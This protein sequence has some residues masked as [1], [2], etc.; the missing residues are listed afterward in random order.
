MLLLSVL[1]TT[2]FAQ[3]RAVVRDIALVQDGCYVQLSMSV[4]M[5]A[6]HLAS[7]DRIVL[8]PRLVGKCDTVDFP[9]VIV[10]GRGVYY[11]YVRDQIAP[12]AFMIRHAK[13][14][15]VTR[16]VRS[17]PY[18]PWMD[19]ATLVIT[20]YDG[21]ICG[22]YATKD[23]LT[24]SRANERIPQSSLQPDIYKSFRQ[25]HSLLALKSNLLFDAALIPNIEI[26]AQLGRDSRW[27][28]MAEDWFPWFR[29]RHNRQGDTNRYHRTDQRPTKNSWQLWMLGMELR[30]W[31]GP[32]CD[33]SR[34]KLSG[35]FAGI[36]AAGGK[37]DWEYNSSGDQGEFT[38]LGLTIGHSWVLNDRLNLEL[39]ASGG[40]VGGPRRH[41]QGEFDDARLIFQHDGCLHYFGPTK[42]KLSLVWLLPSRFQ[43]KGGC[44]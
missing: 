17:L 44:R 3:S 26:E 13:D 21:D 29:T 7:G 39:S 23:E 25:Y 30:Y 33:R 6:S 5:G 20:T 1:V 32:R 15:C 38:S 8:T 37:Y 18:Q 24:V 31:F 28:L 10:C 4:R 22:R 2:A 36:Y 42:L 14:S 41:Y 19:Q 40:Y 12:D 16:Y 9:Q 27:S 43:K 34:P 11:N 35:T